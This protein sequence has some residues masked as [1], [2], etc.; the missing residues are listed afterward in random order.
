M[1]KILFSLYL[2]G[3]LLFFSSF[4]GNTTPSEMTT[5]EGSEVKNWETGKTTHFRLAAY[6]L[7]SFAMF[8]DVILDSSDF[9]H[10]QKG[11]GYRDYLIVTAK[12]FFLSIPVSVG[13]FTILA[14]I[15]LI[16]HIRTQ[17]ITKS[18]L[19]YFLKAG[20]FFMPVASVILAINFYN[21]AT[22]YNPYFHLGIGAYLIVAAYLLIGIT[23][24][25]L[26]ESEK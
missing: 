20:S 5:A 18:K 12:R 13:W 15:L 26:A 17:K 21:E 6:P 8:I 9:E 16:W 3:L 2:L 24:L 4:F 1:R 11:D 7:V 10:G 22:L 23:L 14:S 19:R 25:K